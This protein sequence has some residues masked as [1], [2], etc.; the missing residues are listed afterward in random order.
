MKRKK[1]DKKKLKYYYD[2]ETLKRFM[3]MSA[4]ATLNWLEE[5]NR[6]FDK[7]V[8]KKTKKLQ[9]KLKQEGW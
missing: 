9:Q 7:V 6:F 5:A 2:D 4:K 3:N 8:P 1:T